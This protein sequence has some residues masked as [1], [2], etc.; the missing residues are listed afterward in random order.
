MRVL[1]DVKEKSEFLGGASER[2][3]VVRRCGGLGCH[4]ERLV[5]VVGRSAG[6]GR[7][8][9]RVDDEGVERRQVKDEREL[10]KVGVVVLGEVS[11]RVSM[12]MSAR[13]LKDDSERRP[14]FE[15]AE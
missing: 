5:G 11:A 3:V 10:E 8:K 12:A 9:A 1:R 14:N 7:E 6:V 4:D 2:G 13:G 15:R